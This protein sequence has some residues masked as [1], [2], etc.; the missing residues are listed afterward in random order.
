[1]ILQLKYYG[2]YRENTAKSG[3]N[4][5]L[6]LSAVTQIYILGGI[7]VYSA[8]SE[9]GKQDFYKAPVCQLLSVQSGQNFQRTQIGNL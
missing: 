2:K 4:I 6:H 3:F 5:C 8:N 9:C 1:M 7:S